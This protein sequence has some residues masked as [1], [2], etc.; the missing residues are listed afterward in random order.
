M[1]WASLSKLEARCTDRK[2]PFRLRSQGHA[3]ALTGRPRV[4][5][6]RSTVRKLIGKAAASRDQLW[7][8]WEPSVSGRV[9]ARSPPCVPFVYVSHSSEA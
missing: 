6:G 9:L 7:L 3:S 8:S 5:E 1:Q 2:L 4:A